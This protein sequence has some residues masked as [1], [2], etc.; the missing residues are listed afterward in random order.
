MALWG[1]S[2]WF[3]VVLEVV[4]RGV[5]GDGVEKVG[6]GLV[7]MPRSQDL[8]GW[9]EPWECGCRTSGGVLAAQARGWEVARERR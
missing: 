4:T 7:C 2:R 9:S 5:P 1:S 3:D 8:G 6:G